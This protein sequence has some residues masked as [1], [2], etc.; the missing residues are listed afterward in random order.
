MIACF[1]PRREMR[2]DEG[3]VVNASQVSQHAITSV[4]PGHGHNKRAS[5]GI[6]SD[7]DEHGKGKVYQVQ[8]H[9]ERTAEQ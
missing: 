7:G 6:T 4:R 9:K 3:S 5:N 8:P 1:W 2:V